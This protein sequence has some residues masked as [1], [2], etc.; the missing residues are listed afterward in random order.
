MSNIKFGIYV[1]YINTRD[2]KQGRS[3]NIKV[4]GRELLCM[5]RK[6]TKLNDNRG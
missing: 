3:R 5:D 6:W 2:H 4:N 1:P